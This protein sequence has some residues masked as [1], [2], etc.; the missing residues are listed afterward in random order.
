MKHY[1]DASP[2]WPIKVKYYE[3]Y[4]ILKKENYKAKE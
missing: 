4:L 1:Y 3:F 2:G